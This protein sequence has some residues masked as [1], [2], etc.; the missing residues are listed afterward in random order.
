MDRIASHP[1][2]REELIKNGLERV[3]NFSWEKAGKEMLAVV[4]RA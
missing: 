2:V 1:E 3:K 4:Q